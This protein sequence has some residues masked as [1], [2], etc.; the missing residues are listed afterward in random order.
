MAGY[1]LDNS[2]DRARRRL[3]RLEQ[4]LDPMTQRRMASLGVGPGAR[5]LE[6]GGGG[7]SVANWLCGQV[8]PTGNVLATDINIQLLEDIK[9]PNFAAQRH[10]ILIDDLPEA[11]FDFVHTRWLLHHLPRPDD[12][13]RRMIGALKP[14]GWLLVEEVDFF[15]VRASSSEAYTRFMVALTDTVVKASGRDCFWARELPA[16][17]AGMGL[18]EVGGE[19]D[20]SVIQGGSPT[21]EFF[22]LTGEQMRERMLEAKAL[23]EEQFDQGMA[24]LNDP[25]FWAFGGGGVAVWGQRAA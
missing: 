23:T 9:H 8:G 11:T 5:C 6:V 17:V 16:I 12:V 18:V 13:V 15:P 1:A 22:A 25:A 21:A 4:Y 24:L 7:G 3:A 19:G 2:W 14:G 20:F 10:D